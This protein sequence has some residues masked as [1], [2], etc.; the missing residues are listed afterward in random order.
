MSHV[1]NNV[2][3]SKTGCIVV[4]GTGCFL[5]MSAAVLL[6][7]RVQSFERKDVRAIAE[8]KWKR[9]RKV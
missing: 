2:G 1:V 7:H 6:E 4:S 8:D 3:Y 9:K 5:Y